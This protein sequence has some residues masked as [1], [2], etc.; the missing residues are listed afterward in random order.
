MA[1]HWKSLTPR[2][3]KIGLRILL[4][5][6]LILQVIVLSFQ[7][8]YGHVPLPANSLNRLLAKRSLNGLRIE[9]D[10]YQLRLDGQIEAFA[11]KIFRVD[12][13]KP[14]LQTSRATL[15]WGMQSNKVP[16][17]NI[18]K[19]VLSAGTI[20]LPAVHSPDGKHMALLSDVAIDL[21]INKKHVRANAISAR[22][23]DWVL[24][25][26]LE[27]PI[28]DGTSIDLS[29]TLDKLHKLAS[30]IPALKAQHESIQK[31]TITF[32]I[33]AKDS[34]GI[35]VDLLLSVLSVEN[36]IG[37]ASHVSLDLAAE[38]EEGEFRLKDAGLLSCD[39]LFI[40]SRDL[41]AI[42]TRC[43]I[44]PQEF[45]KLIQMRIP[46]MNISAKQIQLADY[47]L[48]H[49]LFQFSE[50]EPGSLLLDGITSLY[51][52]V[53]SFSTNYK[54]E[55]NSG[56]LHARG[57]LDP[58]MLIEKLPKA[59]RKELPEITI[60]EHLR[61]DISIG[62]S[63]ATGLSHAQF[64]LDT[65]WARIDGITFDLVRMKGR[66]SNGI[67]EAEKLIAYREN[68][69]AKANI[70]LNTQK[71]TINVLAKG[72][73][74]PSD[75]N[76]MLPSWWGNIFKDF[77]INADNPAEASFAVQSE[78]LKG[79]ATSFFGEVKLKNSNYSGVPLSRARVVVNGTPFHISLD[80]SDIESSEGD[81]QGRIDLTRRQDGIPSLVA[82]HLDVESGLSTQATRNLVGEQLYRRTVGDFTCT[83]RP[84][85]KLTGSS[86]FTKRYPEYSGKSHFSF[87]ADS[88]GSLIY[89]GTS[90]DYL[91]L[92]GYSCDNVTQLRDITFGYAGGTGSGEIDIH[93]RLE[94]PGKAVVKVDLNNARY[95]K[96]IQNLPILNSPENDHTTHDGVN[97]HTGMNGSLDAHLHASGPLDDLYGFSG[98][99]N[100]II[101]GKRLG[102]IQLLGPLSLLLQD[103]ALGFT[104]FELNRMAGDLQLEDGLAHF[105]KLGING[106]LTSIEATGSVE[107]ES[108]ELNMQ[109]AVHLFG[110]ITDR[111]NPIYQI[112][113]ILNPLTRLLRF[114]LRGTITE[115]Q[116]RSIY[117]PRKLIP[118]F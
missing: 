42:D 39:Q 64:D 117:D 80:I 110:N 96:A 70:R 49:S 16:N 103:T 112:T 37:R 75:Y 72:D 101:Q 81:F 92:N 55:E 6:T 82:L 5:T 2:L 48:D 25:G 60:P 67:A 79:S 51:G 94:K 56:T 77:S 7:L 50:A 33:F 54:F 57:K 76:Q 38:F 68:Q 44:N 31:P 116:W 69:Y 74:L 30:K 19:I 26:T 53:S 41:L 63:E 104:S 71:G 21:E 85:I 27:L 46:E 98:Q 35:E 13:T 10:A 93:S 45:N 18:Y 99:G 111:Q 36:E 12:G 66:Y 32:N 65:R 23:D 84:L 29:K 24:R 17:I 89:S 9:A 107:L 114:E 97:N 22:L 88:N 109:V 14:L 83:G 115:Q 20:Y 106:P 87:H 73:I 1:K 62:F 108:Q 28:A 4:M 43:R 34:G 86:Y 58:H 11:L 100:F 91:K 90:L 8:Y 15:R 47:Q 52:Q 3:I 40:V 102:T 59:A 105:S 61:Y 118:G 113:D 78:N 95:S